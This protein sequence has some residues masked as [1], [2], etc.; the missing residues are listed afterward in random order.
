MARLRPA[1]LR[2]T[3]AKRGEDEGVRCTHLVI[4]ASPCM[5]VFTFARP[6]APTAFAIKNRREESLDS[7]MTANCHAAVCNASHGMPTR[8][9]A[10]N[11]KL[12]RQRAAVAAGR[13]AVPR[14]NR[15]SDKHPKPAGNR[16]VRVYGPPEVHRAMRQAALDNGYRCTSD[17]YVEAEGAH[18]HAR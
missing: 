12:P 4:G 14:S 6:D 2:G 13:E 3:S 5:A 8:R 15:P 17:V 16:K 9:P 11:D 18:A 7:S 10:L 1:P